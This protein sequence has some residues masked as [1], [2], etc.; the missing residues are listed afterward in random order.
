MK[1]LLFDADETIWHFKA[2]EKI[3]LSAVYKKYGLPDT[4]ETTAEYMVGNLSCW[5]DYEKGLINLNELEVLRWKLF[6]SR[7]GKNYSAEE[8]A[9]FFGDVLSH[10]GIL[11]YGAK[12]FLESISSYDKALVTNGISR[13]QRARIKDTGLDKYF[14]KI[15]ISDEIGYRK[16][17]KE[18]FDY[19]LKDI[20]KNKEDCIMIG[21]SEKSDIK[22]AINA[23]LESIYISFKG[24]KS[25]LAT[26]SV[27]SYEELRALIERI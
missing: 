22:G 1:Y 13:I 27:S 2:T 4:E 18:L 21:D 26:Y 10:N 9:S 24:E 19:V 15:F 25:S 7:I 3:G 11:L 14:N 8:A 12:E 23:G 20:N 16:P 6:F 17:Q 5:S